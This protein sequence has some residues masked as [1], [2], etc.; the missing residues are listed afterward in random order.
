MTADEYR[1]IV[2]VFLD[3]RSLRKTAE[4]TKHGFRLVQRV[5]QQGDGPGRPSAYEVIE[6]QA[7]LERVRLARQAAETATFSR[8]V[9][10]K[11]L[12]GAGAQLADLEV[13]LAAVED[14]RTLREAVSALRELAA[15]GRELYGAPAEAPPLRVA[16]EPPSGIDPAEA[17]A[18]A[19][20]F[21]ARYPLA[22]APGL[23]EATVAHIAA[24]QA[25]LAELA[26]EAADEEEA[27]G[28]PAGSV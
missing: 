12:A 2:R 15:L 1:E 19:E 14:P 24:K 27:A 13:K 11:M 28:D 6:E 16:L 8:A 25:R 5:V 9:F 3:T 7:E 17:R 20:R 4:Q 22:F 18:I 23:A 26:G 10:R 21:R